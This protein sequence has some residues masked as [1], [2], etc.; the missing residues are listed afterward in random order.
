MERIADLVVTS[1]HSIQARVLRILKAFE[2]V[3]T[4][5]WLAPSYG[6][7]LIAETMLTR[8]CSSAAGWLLAWMFHCQGAGPGLALVDL[9]AM[10]M[11][12]VKP[13]IICFEPSL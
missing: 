7:L 10:Q 4:R 1:R 5:C 11:S 13:S 3:G 8:V 12:A 9:L 2:M 6:L